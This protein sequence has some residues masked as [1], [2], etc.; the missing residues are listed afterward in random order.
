MKI[1]IIANMKSF[2]LYVYNLRLP[3]RTVYYYSSQ[4]TLAQ[5]NI[6]N[7]NGIKQLIIC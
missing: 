2:F 4:N 5:L 6:Y 1:E 3:L 7:K